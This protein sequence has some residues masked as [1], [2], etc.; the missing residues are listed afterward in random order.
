MQFPRR[1]IAIA[2]FVKDGSY[3]ADIGADHGLLELLLVSK[4]KDV[5]IFAVENK[6]GP[7]EIL[8]KA[9]LPL[10]GVEASLSNGLRE[11]PED[12]DTLI[13]AGMG[14]I[15]ICKI[16][17]ARPEKL[18][19][20]DT[21][22]VDA[23]RNIGLVRRKFASLGYE[24]KEEKLIQKSGIYYCIILFNKINGVPNYTEDQLDFGVKVFENK[25]WP[26]Y[27]K[28]LI[29]QRNDVLNEIEGKPGLDKKR[30][31]LKSEIERI[32]KYGKD[33]TI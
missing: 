26:A 21:V 9:V 32:K 3:I 11:I 2:N 5:R 4:K 20:I 10:N 12:I 22:I 14:G 25:E 19:N 1:L 27:K 8:K 29:K 31:L 18:K 23:H 24:I 7:F 15:N 28:W 13:I 17:D 30:N 6:K 16:V 33:E